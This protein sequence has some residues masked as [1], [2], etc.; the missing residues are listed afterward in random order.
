MTVP[1]AR[2]APVRPEPTWELVQKRNNVERLKRERFPF[3]IERDFEG[4][5]ADDYLSLPEEDV[6]RLQWYGLYHDKPKVGSFM[7]RVKLAGGQATPEQLREIARVAREHGTG[8]YLELSTRQNVQLHGIRM[9]DF[10]AVLG[11]LAAVGLTTLGG[12]GDT[13]RNITA[14]PV[15]GIAA[16]ELFDVTPTLAEA[17]GF[18][19]GNPTYSDLPRK[20]KITVA[21]CPHHCNAPEM[22]C[23][24]LIGT[25]QAGR[26][27]YAVRVG[28]GLSTVP[29]L[30]RSLGAF[31]PREEA[32][33]VLKAILD[34]WREDLRYRMSRVKARLKFM[35]DDLGPEGVRERVEARLG[36][37]LEDLEEEPVAA[38]ATTHTGVHPQRQPGLSY[39]G[40]AVFGGAVKADDLEAIGEVA[41]ERGLGVRLTR[42]QNFILTGI[43][44]SAVAEVVERVEAL[45]FPSKS[46]TL[47]AASLGCTGQPLCNYAVAETK[48]TMRSL[49]TRLEGRFGERAGDLRVHV[50]GC[51]H[52]CAHHWTGDIGLQGS[53]ARERDAAGG[54]IS[55]YDV[56]L[57]GGY[58][59]EAQV[60]RPLLRRVKTEEVGEAV[61]RLVG[62]YLERRDG[63]EAFA[64]FMRR[65]PDAEIL[66]AAGVAPTA[67]QLAES[68]DEE[69]A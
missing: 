28:G 19:Y 69:D 27:G 62:F 36:R 68:E 15:A 35:V 66:A 41:A 9:K 67:K 52:A 11:R 48:A 25:R 14:C 55:A 43:P 49:V 13:V 64:S 26:E 50:D 42:F 22:H 1:P 38:G 7:L 61:E 31:V 34:A 21:A 24:A 4:Y 63:S 59:A 54:K 32:L 60:G 30:S 16:D 45:G 20:H 23:I 58:G 47:R 8:D 17:A 10:K 46:S 53:T 57:R 44:R 37:R 51:P 18:F 6:V 65:L 5:A 2:P 39:A 29:R 12:C 56:Y 33:D 40:F 3:E